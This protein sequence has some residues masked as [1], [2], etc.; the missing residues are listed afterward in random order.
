MQVQV[1]V[2][3]VGTSAVAWLLVAWP[4]PH[5]NY[6][7]L[8]PGAGGKPP[9]HKRTSRSS[10]HHKRHDAPAGTGAGVAGSAAAA[11]K[12]AT[13]G[14][15]EAARVS[16]S[17]QEGGIKAHREDEDASSTSASVFGDGSEA[18]HEARAPPILLRRQYT[19]QGDGMALAVPS[20]KGGWAGYGSAYRRHACAL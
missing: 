8:A 16:S 19:D 17:G 11:G 3:V 1:K 10:A 7:D 12:A 9:G 15:A 4:A 14:G 18:G 5:P 6:L 2:A 20:S 13:R